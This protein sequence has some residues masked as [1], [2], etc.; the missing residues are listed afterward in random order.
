VGKRLLS[1]VQKR[2]CKVK[3]GLLFHVEI[4]RGRRMP[5]AS[6]LR[7]KRMPPE[8]HQLQA[9]NPIRSGRLSDV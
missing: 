7:L 3:N 5:S 6:Y 2:R 1:S 8:E 9:C 4:H